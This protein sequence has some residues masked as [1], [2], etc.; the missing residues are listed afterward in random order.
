MTTRALRGAV[1]FLLL[2]PAAFA[3]ETLTCGCECECAA[4]TPPVCEPPPPPPIC[5]EPPPSPPPPPPPPPLTG[6]YLPPDHG[7]IVVSDDP[8]CPGIV[9]DGVADD[10]AAIQACVEVWASRRKSGGDSAES[11]ETLLFTE[12]YRISDGIVQRSQETDPNGLHYERSFQTYRFVNGAKLILSA[13][14]PG[15]GDAN[16]PKAV[17]R[18]G[19]P[20]AG[21]NPI[22]ATCCTGSAL[23]N[24]IRDMVIE[25]EDGNPGAIGV[26]HVGNNMN[27]VRGLKVVAAPG[28]CRAGFALNAKWPGPMVIDELDVGGCDHGVQFYHPYA[29]VVFRRL[30][31][32]GQRLAGVDAYRSHA[33][34][35]DPD[36]Q[37]DSGVPAFLL[38][39]FGGGPGGLTTILG[40]TLAGAGPVAI[41]SL[42]TTGE[43]SS[44]RMWLF[45]RG[46]TVDGY[47]KAIDDF[48]NQV[49][50]M[51]AEYASVPPEIVHPAA[52]LT[53]LG[54]AVPPHPHKQHPNPAD[55]VSARAFM[56][57]PNDLSASLTSAAV[58]AAID[59][60]SC[61]KVV[62]LPGGVLASDTIR[63][64]GCAE[65]VI[66]FDTTISAVGD[67]MRV[68]AFKPLFAMESDHAVELEDIKADRGDRF[69]SPLPHPRTVHVGT[70][71]LILTNVLHLTN[72]ESLPGAGPLFVEN[73]CCDRFRMLAG[74]AAV[75]ISPNVE[76]FAAPLSGDPAGRPDIEVVGGD[77]VIVGFKTE[78]NDGPFL[79]ATNARVE[80]WGAWH[81][82][83]LQN[84]NASPGPI[85]ELIDSEALIQ[86]DG[87]NGVKWDPTGC[88]TRA[89]ATGDPDGC[90]KNTVP[91]PG[92]IRRQLWFLERPPEPTPDP[93][94]TP[95]PEPTP[96]PTPMV[97]LRWAPPADVGDGVTGYRL[98]RGV[99]SRAYEP[100]VEL[101]NPEPGADG[102][103]AAVTELD[104]AET[105][106]LALTAVGPGGE[107][108][109]SNEVTLP[110]RL[111]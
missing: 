104:P 90:V 7:M 15:F 58:Q 18:T 48:A 24:S 43:N 75:L 56:P 5:E 81:Y 111:P 38:R 57:D 92:I 21:S 54:L 20:G 53:S 2:A 11:S 32:R 36:I 109:L 68:P 10:T 85:Y 55:W 71:P 89:G 101:G 45:A 12:T 46:V 3:A 35:L 76:A 51:P 98:H 64:R 33:T 69:N 34:F 1:L 107:S 97:Q 9:G 50:T 102:A 40:G 79:K 52:S 66:G 39:G 96:T 8:S 61:P 103:L 23:Q 72:Y 80:S 67:S 30:K 41:K 106:Y 77:A 27:S 84:G 25:I 59:A 99:A 105:W 88:V 13:N 42:L 63:L 70:G 22:G 78:G 87:L 19:N 17:W 4:P 60:P 16:A 82:S 93:A 28:S 47:A 31:L 108:E 29:N 110:A 26:D 94:P 83:S 95:T 62:Y 73:S 14:A 74:N 44:G 65:R 86:Y 100:P 91:V 6:D 37:E 49:V